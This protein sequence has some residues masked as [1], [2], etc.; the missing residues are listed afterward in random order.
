[1]QKTSRMKTILDPKA[2]SIIIRRTSLQH[3]NKH[4]AIWF[5][6]NIKE[7][8]FISQLKPKTICKASEMI[9]PYRPIILLL[10]L[11]K[12]YPRWLWNIT[13]KPIVSESITPASIFIFT[14]Q[15]G[16]CQRTA[17]DRTPGWTSLVG[18]WCTDRNISCMEWALAAT[19]KPLQR[20][21][22]DKHR[23]RAPHNW[24]QRQAICP[25]TSIN[26][27]STTLNHHCWKSNPPVAYT[28]DKWHKSQTCLA[29]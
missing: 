9:E 19:E 10:A 7:M 28:Q 2:K 20:L 24:L 21:C 27:S 12:T 29:W 1:M 6:H 26:P 18:C 3:I 13:P 8:K 15:R 16:G 22:A 25:K 4:F 5:S 17:K 14:K 11:A 23:L